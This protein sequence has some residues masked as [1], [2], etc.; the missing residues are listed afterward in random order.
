MST[1]VC[2]LHNGRSHSAHFVR[3]LRMYIRFTKLV[4]V[5]SLMILLAGCSSAD[6]DPCEGLTT[7]RVSENKALLF[8]DD[9]SECLI[10][11]EGQDIMDGAGGNDVLIGG[12]DTDLMSGGAGDDTF[13]IGLG[14][15]MDVIAGGSGTDTITFSPEI[16]I[17]ML[18]IRE[19]D[20]VISVQIEQ[21]DR[22]S[23]VSFGADYSGET[24]EQ[25][26][27][28]DGNLLTVADLFA[29]IEREAQRQDEFRRTLIQAE[30]IDVASTDEDESLLQAT[31]ETIR[32]SN[33]TALCAE[34]GPYPRP[35]LN[36]DGKG[37]GP[38]HEFTAGFYGLP[39]DNRA[40]VQRQQFAALATAGLFHEDAIT[41]ADGESGVRY[42]LTWDG[43]ALQTRKGCF[44][45][46]YR[47]LDQVINYRPT[48]K[49]VQG[50]DVY[51]VTATTR[52]VD[53]ELWVKRPE[54]SAAFPD[55]AEELA[56]KSLEVIV[57][58]RGDDWFA[59]L[60]SG[61]PAQ[62]VASAPGWRALPE[63]R[64]L[65]AV[66]E[67]LFFGTIG[68][69]TV[70]TALPM[71]GTAKFDTRGAA[72][73]TY[74]RFPLR[75][76]QNKVYKEADIA[77]WDMLVGFGVATRHD[78]HETD[79]RGKPVRFLE[80]R[81]TPGYPVRNPTRSACLE[82]GETRFEVLHARRS[83]PTTIVLLGRRV[84]TSPYDWAKSPAFLGEHPQVQRMF[85][86]GLPVKYSIS[87][88]EG[89]P[90]TFQGST[91]VSRP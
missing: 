20:G 31:A 47:D 62:G 43:W 27:F 64:D 8:G 51:V 77:Y 84:A 80:Y 2:V 79:K 89:Q 18:S 17:S 40:T 45:Y 57:L 67:R 1:I 34:P 7:L 37:F 36:H 22:W 55:I 9:K 35:D 86:D 3:V 25:V 48:G 54:V 49:T 81:V 63:L 21:G 78:R 23:Y 41:S 5:L 69:G 10:G 85:G 29:Q 33:S 71:L 75:D 38:K 44:H 61:N 4:A 90:L 16:S 74:T 66:E 59:T 88:R 32:L 58:R 12:A 68:R 28:A 42:R 70:C 13:V 39:E 82:I 50:K 91:G 24:T 83:H 19:D 15:G 52:V 60:R 87:D 73:L 46:G 65:L 30:T 14:D 56:G 53:G 26:R 6:A 11:S 76:D 72:Y